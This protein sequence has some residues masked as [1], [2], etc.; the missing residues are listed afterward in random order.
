MK[1]SF[2]STWT[3]QLMFGFTLLLVS[4]LAVN[5]SY[6]KSFKIRN[7]VTSIIEKNGGF[8]TEAKEIIN[9]YIRNSGYKSTG[10]CPYHSGDLEYGISD[11]ASGV[12]PTQITLTNND[13]YFYCI[14]KHNANNS[15]VTDINYEII[16]FYK[17]NIPLFGDFATFT[18]KG[19]TT[20]LAEKSDLFDSIY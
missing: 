4:F 11:L 9:D 14:K 17:F 2:G 15:Q 18:V 1:E 20:D 8:T 16:M 19:K 6:S 12:T 7:E 5:I 3:M 10:K 13:N